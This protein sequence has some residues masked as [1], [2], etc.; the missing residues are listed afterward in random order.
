MI[1][2]ITE[3]FNYFPS[4]IYNKI[5]VCKEKLDNLEEIRVRINRNILLKIGQVEHKVDYRIN[6]KEVLEILQRICEN[7]I[8]TYQNQIC[9]GFITIKGRT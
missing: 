2:T 4:N 9:N 1:N 3:I 6:D 7:S 8:Y 5:T